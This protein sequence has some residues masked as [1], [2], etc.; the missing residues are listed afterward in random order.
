MGQHGRLVLGPAFPSAAWARRQAPGLISQGL[1]L[2]PA[3]NA[4]LTG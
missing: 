2:S 1:I 3:W 4:G